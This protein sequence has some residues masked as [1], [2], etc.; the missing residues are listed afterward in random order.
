MGESMFPSADAVSF[1]CG[2]P[3][4]IREAESIMKDSYIK[5]HYVKLDLPENQ[6][7]SDFVSKSKCKSATSV[8]KGPVIV[9]DTSLCFN[10]LHGLPGPYIKWFYEKLGSEGLHRL[11]AGWEDKSASA[12][13][14]LAFTEGPGKEVF[15]FSGEVKGTIV[16]PRGDYGFGWDSCFQPEGSVRT[17][18][19]MSSEEKNEF[20]H[21]HKALLKLK[22]YLISQISG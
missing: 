19:E 12:V 22:A 2:N 8:V 20:S 16:P 5:I 10:A 3:G 9:E 18:A 13:C 7:D 11:L 15:L 21:R 6:G 14:T 17:F 1:V 4:K